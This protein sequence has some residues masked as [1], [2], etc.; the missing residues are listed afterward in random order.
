MLLFILKSITG[1]LQPAPI[2]EHS[3]LMTSH[4]AG[5]APQTQ[6]PTLALTSGPE[7]NKLCWGK[8]KKGSAM[9]SE[10]AK[11][12]LEEGSRSSGG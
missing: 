2:K 9:E 11:Q 6:A 7:P 10:K 4:G 1:T 5:A 3:Q 8:C 12:C